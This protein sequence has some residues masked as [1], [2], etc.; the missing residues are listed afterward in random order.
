MDNS[1]LYFSLR[2]HH[3]V[4]PLE[5]SPQAPT[6]QVRSSQGQAIF[7]DS[8]G[9]LFHMYIKMTEGEDEKMTKRWQKDADGILIF[10]SPYI[11]TALE[12][13]D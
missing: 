3:Q 13:S 12:P 6:E 2:Y 9:P 10:V 7:S 11:N 5:A 8:S 1:M 4:H